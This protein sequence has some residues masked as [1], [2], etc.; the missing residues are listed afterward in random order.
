MRRQV[1]LGA[2]N[3]ETAEDIS[4]LK[5]LTRRLLSWIEIVIDKPAECPAWLGRA[6]LAG[7][8]A[9]L[10]DLLLR[11]NEASVK[12]DTVS[13]SDDVALD[14]KDVELVKHFLRRMQ[15]AD[16]A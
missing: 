5:S 16:E 7:I 14:A 15:Q 9:T 13:A 6:S 4:R 8:V 2:G 3:V 10:A 1:E 12:V 11:L